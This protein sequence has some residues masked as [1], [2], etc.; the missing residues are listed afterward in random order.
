[1]HSQLKHYI[2]TITYKSQILPAASLFVITE[3]ETDELIE[4]KCDEMKMDNALA[5]KP[6][7]NFLFTL[8][9]WRIIH[10]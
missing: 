1:V 3:M 7:N 2:Y 10:Y 9:S 6:G 8:Y 4:T 5:V